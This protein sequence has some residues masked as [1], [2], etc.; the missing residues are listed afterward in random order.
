MHM[1]INS[2]KQAIGLIVGFSIRETGRD[3]AML[4]VSIDNGAITYEGRAT[5]VDNIVTNAGLAAIK[6]RDLSVSMV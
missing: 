5:E 2:K 3:D 4:R 1:I 6:G